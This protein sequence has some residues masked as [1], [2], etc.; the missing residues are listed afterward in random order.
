MLD[1]SAGAPGLQPNVVSTG[2]PQ[3]D[4][5]T[6]TTATAAGDDGG[7]ASPSAPAVDNPAARKAANGFMKAWLRSDRDAEAWHTGVAK[8]ATDA[9]AKKLVGVDP[10][11][12]PAKRTTGPGVLSLQTNGYAEMAFPVDSGEVRLRLVRQD[13]TWL[14]DGVDWLRA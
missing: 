4:P 1:R 7:A 13:T 2:L 8:F 6:T 12:V 9:L 3:V 11:G 14:V 5:S 10:A